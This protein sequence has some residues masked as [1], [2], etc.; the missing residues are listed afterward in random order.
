M[1]NETKKDLEDLMI[2]EIKKELDNPKALTEA[3][4]NKYGYSYNDFINKLIL[5]R[6]RNRKQNF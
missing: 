3:I 2:Q 4:K 1:N 6:K 5:F